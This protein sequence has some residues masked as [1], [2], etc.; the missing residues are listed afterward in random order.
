MLRPPIWNPIAKAY[1]TSRQNL[2]ELRR[3]YDLTPADFIEPDRLFFILL[4]R[5]KGSPLRTKLIQP[6]MR[7]KIRRKLSKKIKL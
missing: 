6:A 1:G 4:E 3:R 5:A 7:Q 2:H